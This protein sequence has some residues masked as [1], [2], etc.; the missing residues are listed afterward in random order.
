MRTHT[1]MRMF[2]CVQTSTHASYTY[3]CTCLRIKARFRP[4][5]ARAVVARGRCRVPPPRPARRWRASAPLGLGAE[6]SLRSPALG[7]GDAADR[8]AAVAVRWGVGEVQGA[9]AAVGAPSAHTQVHMH[10]SRDQAPHEG[11][12]RQPTLRGRRPPLGGNGLVYGS[13]RDRSG[14]TGLGMGR[15]KE[16]WV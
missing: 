4:G 13:M 11:T 1:L 10:S 6:R 8:R 12:Q 15:P 7:Q 2:T 16:G 14:P 5:V 9:A 3:A